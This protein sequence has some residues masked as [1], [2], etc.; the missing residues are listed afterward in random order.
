MKHLLNIVLATLIMGPA[1]IGTASDPSAAFRQDPAVTYST[2]AVSVKKAVQDIAKV[3]GAK[4]D[5]ADAAA[6]E[7]VV[8]SVKDAPLS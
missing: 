4:L 7:I 1:S 5:V 6:N 8:I 2:V 3:T